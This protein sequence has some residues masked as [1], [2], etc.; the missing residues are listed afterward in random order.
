M[1]SSSSVPKRAKKEEEEEEEEEK[2]KI[3]DDT[4]GDKESAAIARTVV[5]F[6][7]RDRLKETQL[8]EDKKQGREIEDFSF[9]QFLAKFAGKNFDGDGINYAVVH[10]MVRTY[11]LLYATVRGQTERAVDL[12]TTGNVIFRL[13]IKREKTRNFGKNN[14]LEY[15]YYHASPLEF[16]VCYNNSE[17]IKALVNH[18]NFKIRTDGEEQI[19]PDSTRRTTDHLLRRLL[20]CDTYG[21]KMNDDTL[22]FLLGLKYEN[23]PT[24]NVI[25][26]GL[27]ILADL[28]TSD[29]EESIRRYEIIRPFVWYPGKEKLQLVAPFMDRIITSSTRASSPSHYIPLIRKLT[30]EQMN[31]CVP[32]EPGCLHDNELTCVCEH[33]L[34]SV[35]ATVRLWDM[36]Y[37]QY[38]PAMLIILAQRSDYVLD[39]TKHTG[40]ERKTVMHLA[41]DRHDNASLGK[42]REK[43]SEGPRIEPREVN[44]YSFLFYRFHH[45]H[46][47]EN[48]DALSEIEDLDEYRSQGFD[49]SYSVPWSNHVHDKPNDCLCGHSL[50]TLAF[51]DNGSEA[52]QKYLATLSRAD[53]TLMETMVEDN[54]LHNAYNRIAKYI[55]TPP[56]DSRAEIKFDFKG[57]LIGPDKIPLIYYVIK[58]LKHNKTHHELFRLFIDRISRDAPWLL[59][60][61]GYT[62]KNLLVTPIEFAV[63]FS[64]SKGH[65]NP[66]RAPTIQPKNPDR[67]TRRLYGAN[68]HPVPAPVYLDHPDPLFILHAPPNPQAVDAGED[69]EEFDE[70]QMDSRPLENTTHWIIA[71][72]IDYGAQVS[73][74]AIKIAGTGLVKHKVVGVPGATNPF[75]SGRTMRF[76]YNRNKENPNPAELYVPGRN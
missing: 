39:V 42:L 51:L 74:L 70:E 31:F 28:Q 27:E 62:M 20:R 24:E 45:E 50:F 29:E 23:R 67:K 64:S 30:K 14:I 60:H 53:R 49:L 43:W 12:I 18:E 21:I 59:N 11:E 57:Q 47:D 4:I 44:G 26:P 58:N 8:F 2:E 13:K 38:P 16:A 3:V 68:G 6:G 56:K 5:A 71:T 54:T 40:K 15:Q 33:S 34:F 48:P 55:I 46:I 41:Y 63:W 69:Q 10:D 17:I 19:V 35:I 76:L 7:E 9:S 52:H 1:S 37:S 25:K 75:M 65:I 72:L 36:D 22:K 61:K 66:T 32:V 73:L